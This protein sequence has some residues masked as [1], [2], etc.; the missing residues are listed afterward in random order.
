MFRKKTIRLT[1]KNIIKGIPLISDFPR[2]AKRKFLPQE[3][4]SDSEQFSSSETYWENRYAAGGNSG[5][6][7]YRKL[8]KFKADILNAFVSSKG[9]ESI[10]EFGCGDGSQLKLFSFPRYLGF[11]VSP[12]AISRCRKLFHL[13]DS[14]KFK[15]AKDY[16]GERAELTL[17]LDVIFHL[18]EDDIFEEYMRRLFAS[19]DRYVIIYSSDTDENI[20]GQGPHVKHRKFTEWIEENLDDWRLTENIPNKY[21]YKGDIEKGSSA[22]FYIYKKIENDAVADSPQE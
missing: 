4:L 11:D 5:P 10:I 13:D 17:S 21:P 8:A 7:S 12:T 3:Y 19:P 18:V 16:N 22:N 14:K 2:L 9:I 6:G 1:I 15:L 20:A